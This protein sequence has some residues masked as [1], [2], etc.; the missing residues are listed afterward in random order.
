MGEV[1]DVTA[2][3]DEGF[4]RSSDR[5]AA[6][7]TRAAGRETAP[8]V[9]VRRSNTILYTDRWSATVAFYRDALMLRV[10]L[11]NDW[12]VEFAAGPGAFVSIADAAR[13]S[14]PAGHGDGVTL[15]WQVDDVHEVRS[16]LIDRGIEVGEITVR[17]G[18]KVIDVFDP[19]GNRVEL[20][21]GTAPNRT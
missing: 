4:L 13:S 2:F 21:S 1:T 6:R 10:E 12:F 14:I 9:D 11:R 16:A 8:M 5:E 18:S 3:V 19:S 20:W 7:V 15:S 17:W